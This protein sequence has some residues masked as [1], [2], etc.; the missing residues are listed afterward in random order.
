MSEVSSYRELEESVRA[1]LKA[2][3]LSNFENEARWI[4]AETIGFSVNELLLS[5]ERLPEQSH[6]AQVERALSRRL[7]GEPLSYVLGSADFRGLELSVDP[8]VL[9]PRPE[10]E[11]IVDIVKAALSGSTAKRCL[12]VGVGSGCIAIS[13]LVEVP[14]L[15]MVGTDISA[16]ALE[17]CRH[18]AEQH[19]VGDRLELIQGSVFSGVA[20][21]AFDWVISNPPYIDISDE[22]VAEDVRRYEPHVAL[23]ADH[24]G[25]AIIREILRE[26]KSFMTS[27]GRLIVEHGEGQSNAVVE[28]FSEQGFATVR[29]QDLFGKLRF[30]EGWLDGH[31]SAS[32]QRSQKFG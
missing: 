8:R 17:L 3:G 31:G 21:E 6:I 22:R 5:A 7:S 1:R 10:T 15:T 2:Q 29:H 13:L 26:A 9:I 14:N 19:G 12:E 18:N 20:Q 27:A 32:Q 11:Q 4:V 30:V 25:L 23:F 16:D 24:Q 28:E